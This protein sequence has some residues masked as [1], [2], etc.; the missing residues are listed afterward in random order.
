[1]C[2]INKMSRENYDRLPDD[3]KPHLYSDIINYTPR[4]FN[5]FGPDDIWDKGGYQ[6]AW[7]THN[8]MGSVYEFNPTH[9]FNVPTFEAA[10]ANV[11]RY[12]GELLDCDDEFVRAKV[13][14]QGAKPPSARAMEL[15]Y[16]FQESVRASFR[17]HSEGFGPDDGSGMYR[18]YLPCD[19]EKHYQCGFGSD[20]RWL[21]NVCKIDY[22]RELLAEL[23]MHNNRVWEGVADKMAAYSAIHRNINWNL[24]E[25]AATRYG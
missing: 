19:W 23:Q 18:G 2:Y 14:T 16:D 15:I 10:I 3:G 20:A 25:G 24:L 17:M 7:P 13:T 1:M 12:W 5:G 9:T 21:A 22:E 6:I 4:K 8:Y 11:A